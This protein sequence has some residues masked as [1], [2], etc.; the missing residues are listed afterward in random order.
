[1][2]LAKAYN[3]PVMIHT[4]GSSSW[5]Y[6]DF[7]EMGINGVDTL[8][9]E[10]ANMSPRYLKDPFGGRLFFHGCIMEE[11]ERIGTAVSYAAF[12]SI[13][14]RMTN[15]SGCGRSRPPCLR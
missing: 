9:P 5:V 4:C 6:E 13:G 15:S 3:L 1:M 12:C 11:Q 10:A 2:D 8:Q 14:P 7:I